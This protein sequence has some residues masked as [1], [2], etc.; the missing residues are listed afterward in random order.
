MRSQTAKGVLVVP[1]PGALFRFLSRVA[2]RATRLSIG[3]RTVAHRH[4]FF[5]FYLAQKIKALAV[6]RGELTS[7]PKCALVIVLPFVMHSWTNA[8]GNSEESF[9]FD[10]TPLHRPH[11]FA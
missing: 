11:V 7:L 1:I 3:D 4:V 6:G 10:L 8:G 5:S 2:Y 9:V